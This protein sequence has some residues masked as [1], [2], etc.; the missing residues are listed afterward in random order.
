[1]C[2]SSRAVVVTHPLAYQ[3]VNLSQGGKAESKDLSKELHLTL[4]GSIVSGILGEI[5]KA[6]QR[7]NFMAQTAGSCPHHRRFLSAL[8]FATEIPG[9]I[10]PG[11]VG[12]KTNPVHVLLFLTRFLSQRHRQTLHSHNSRL[13]RGGLLRP[14]PSARRSESVFVEKG[15]ANG[16]GSVLVILA[17][18]VYA[19]PGGD[20]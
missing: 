13:R 16:Q 17:V 7:S 19:I 11:E 9:Q 4:T 5:T 15:S 20:N 1:M 6:V 14:R 10:I 2:S 8:A 12:D 3:I 18:V